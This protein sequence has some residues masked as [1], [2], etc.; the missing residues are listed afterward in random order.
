LQQELPRPY[1]VLDHCQKDNGIK[2]PIAQGE[3][4]V[5]QITAV[6]LVLWKLSLQLF[7][8]LAIELNSGIVLSR[9]QQQA[10]C[11]SSA[12]YV[13]HMPSQIGPYH[14]VSL[15]DHVF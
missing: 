12:A 8:M 9:A 4:F 11:R 14:F 5:I 6:E 2:L 7:N 15:L 1:K 10:G 3:L 13:K